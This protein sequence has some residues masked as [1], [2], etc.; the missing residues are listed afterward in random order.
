MTASHRVYKN[1]YFAA[2][3]ISMWYAILPDFTFTKL[4]DILIFSSAK[5]VGKGLILIIILFYNYYSYTFLPLIFSSYKELTSILYFCADGFWL[6]FI[7]L[8]IS[9][10]IV[11]LI[12]FE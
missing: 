4:F 5:D 7:D 12:N 3:V 11:F 1:V 6:Y 9:L 8:D 10:N 2:V